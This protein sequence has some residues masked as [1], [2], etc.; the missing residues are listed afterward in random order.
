MD[1]SMENCP[2]TPRWHPVLELRH[3]KRGP[4]TRATYL[5]IRLCDDHKQSS[6][7]GNF[8]S[9]E[10]F[11]KI[12]KYMRECGKGAPLQRNTTLDWTPVEVGEKLPTEILLD[13][14]ANGDLA[15]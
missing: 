13:P 8:L 7:L 4:V 11:T 2:N 3:S 10:E 6:N 5:Q 1:C 15:F 9:D 12:A 14:I